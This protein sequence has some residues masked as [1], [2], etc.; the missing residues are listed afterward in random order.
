LNEEFFKQVDPRY[1]MLIT[2]IKIAAKGTRDYERVKYMWY[3]YMQSIISICHGEK[4]GY[5]LGCFPE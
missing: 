2:Y 1:T 5:I 4:Y 3:E